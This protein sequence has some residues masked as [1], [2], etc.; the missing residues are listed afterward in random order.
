MFTVCKNRGS[1]TLSLK[2]KLVF[3]FFLDAWK[4]PRRDAICE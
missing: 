4:Q 2:Q 3:I 1:L